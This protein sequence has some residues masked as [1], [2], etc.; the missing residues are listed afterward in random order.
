MGIILGTGQETGESDKRSRIPKFSFEYILYISNG[1]KEMWK[2]EKNA[3]M[4]V[5][6]NGGID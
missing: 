5:R 2:A 4:G 6:K 3:R 1:K